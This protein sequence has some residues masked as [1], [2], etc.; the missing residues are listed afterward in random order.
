MSPP[1]NTTQSVSAPTRSIA[2]RR[3]IVWSAAFILLCVTATSFGQRSADN[4]PWPG[5]R[6]VRKDSFSAEFA[7]AE[8]GARLR[9]GSALTDST[10]HFRITRNR[11][12]FLEQDGSVALRCL[13]NLLLERITRVI[14]IQRDV[15]SL[16]WTVSGTVTEYQGENYLL[17]T[18]AVINAE[19]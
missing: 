17:I 15:N 3:C 13:E 6:P 12:T 11:L 1:K 14:G 19:S 4:K 10:G 8:R 16:S 18:H 9:E 5:S 2:A 7:V